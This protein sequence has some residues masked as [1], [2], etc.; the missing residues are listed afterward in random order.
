MTTLPVG[1]VGE[2]STASLI[3]PQYAD[4]GGVATQVVLV[5]STDETATGSIEFIGA[6][7]Q[8]V[9]YS[10]AP[11][12]S[13]VVRTAGTAPTIQAGWVRVTP[14]GGTRTPSGLVIFSFKQNGV[15]V[16]Q[17]GVLASPMSTAFRL[18]AE[19]AGN[20]RAGQ[21]GSMQTGIAVVN[22]SAASVPVT[23]ELESL[24]G[25]SAGLTGRITLPAQGHVALF[26]DQIPGLE[27]ALGVQGVLRISA[28]A[29]IAVLGIR[30]RYNERGDFLMSTIPPSNEAD[31]PA[32]TNLYIP[33]FV[34]GGGVTTQ[35]IL[36]GGSAGQSSNGTL[37]FFSQ[38]G[39]V[40]GLRLR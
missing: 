1:P 21:I 3:F 28:P 40:F 8:P 6:D 33:H 32:T 23:F 7:T 5:N 16:S 36:F 26:M 31:P 9:G 4:G 2:T 27:A 29:A 38:T 15:T 10:I 25:A 13:T 11:R 14:E 39:Q 37:R 30:G 20:M 24:S 35:F 12:T 34:D 22:P 19:S 17:A 18:F